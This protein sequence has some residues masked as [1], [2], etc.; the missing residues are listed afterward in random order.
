MSTAHAHRA[1]RSV[2]AALLA[3]LW[4]G[5]ASAARAAQVSP[6]TTE[7]AEEAAHRRLRDFLDAG[8]GPWRKWDKESVPRL[9]ERRVDY[10]RAAG[11]PE[12]PD[13]YVRLRESIPPEL[14]TRIDYWVA[15]A[16]TGIMSVDYACP[17]KGA[18]GESAAAVRP[19]VTDKKDG[20]GGKAVLIGAGV[21]ATGAAVALAAGGGGSS[22][23]S[24][25]TIPPTTPPPTTAP[26]NVTSLHGLY[27]GRL[28][29]GN[30]SVPGCGRAATAPC[31]AQVAGSPN[32]MPASVSFN[33][34]LPSAGVLRPS[35]AMEGF[36]YEGPANGLAGLPG[37]TL[38]LWQQQG[39][40]ANNVLTLDGTVTVTSPGPCNGARIAT[41]VE[42]T[43]N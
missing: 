16:V 37:G 25:N 5:G 32:G 6:G 18:Q 12:R 23:A 17:P 15:A 3:I 26:P 19:G 1:G 42:A 35:G 43:R 27:V 9:C 28:V 7:T 34:D 13:D 8:E 24:P 20:I 4:P 33:G 31:L 29:T 41:R 36:R 21:V 2:V 39:T 38:I 22:S 10:A 30:P 14:R 40:I 11:L